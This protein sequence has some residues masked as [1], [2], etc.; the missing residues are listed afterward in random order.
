VRGTPRG[1]PAGLG[2]AVY[3]VSICQI[4]TG[5][6]LTLRFELV[7]G[8]DGLTRCFSCISIRLA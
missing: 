4:Y 7:E 3:M 2:R 1:R 6:I 5:E 8:V